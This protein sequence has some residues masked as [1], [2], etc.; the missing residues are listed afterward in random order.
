MLRI[1][2]TALIC[3][4]IVLL[5]RAV[6]IYRETWM[7]AHARGT[8][9]DY[10]VYRTAALT[11]EELQDNQFWSNVGEQNPTTFTLYLFAGL[12]SI[13]LCDSIGRWQRKLQQRASPPGDTNTTGERQP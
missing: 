4:A 6:Q 11:D 9:L 7:T 10:F 5:V 12:G 1:L 13:A 2:R 3:V 8:L